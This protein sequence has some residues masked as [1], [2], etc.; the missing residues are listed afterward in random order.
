MYY[1]DFPDGAVVKTPHLHCRGTGS[2]SGQ[3]IKIPHAVEELRAM[4]ICHAKTQTD[5]AK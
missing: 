3:G 4:K 2:I 1:R 5:T